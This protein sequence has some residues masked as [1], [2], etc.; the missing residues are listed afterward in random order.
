MRCGIDTVWQRAWSYLLPIAPSSR[1]IKIKWARKRRKEKENEIKHTTATT[2]P[3]LLN[4]AL[5]MPNNCFWNCFL[6]SNQFTFLF[7][8]S[9][10]EA[11][12]RTSTAFILIYRDDDKSLVSQLGAHCSLKTQPTAYV[13]RQVSHSS[14]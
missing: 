11:H 7:S 3:T 5:L 2:K 10:C 1:F 6:C 4:G 13:K 9:Q 12:Q 14:M 8:Y